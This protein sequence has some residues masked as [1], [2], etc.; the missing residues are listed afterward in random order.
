MVL[1]KMTDPPGVW[2]VRRGRLAAGTGR[3]LL[4]GLLFAFP[5]AAFAQDGGGS[6]RL[7]L[8]E[9]NQPLSNADLFPEITSLDTGT[10][11]AD[12]QPVDL[13]ARFVTDGQGHGRIDITAELAPKW[14]IYS[15]TQP[16]GGPTRTRITITGPAAVKLLSSFSPNNEPARSVSA[17]YNGLT[18]EEHAARVV[19]S[20]P[21][22]LP[23]GFDQGIELKVRGL[24]CRSDDQAGRCLPVSEKLTAKH[25][26]SI[27]DHPIDNVNGGAVALTQADGEAETAK[28]ESDPFRDGKY[29]VQW[30]AAV[31]PPH[32]QP[33]SSGVIEFTAEPKQEYHVYEAATDDRDWATN[34][35]VTEKSGLQVGK[36]TANRKLVSAEILPGSEPQSFYEGEVT[37]QLPFTVPP[38]LEPG[39]KKIQGMIAY[40]A[41]TL[42]SCYR[43]MALKFAIELPVG[44]DA[45][46]PVRFVLNKEKRAVAMDAAAETKWVDP[47]GG[48]N[49]ATEQED[50]EELV[51]TTPVTPIGELPFP[52][53]LGMAFLGGLILNV[54]PCVL[55]VVG[56]KIMG[57][58]SQAGEDRGRVLLLNLVYSLGILSLFAVLAVLAAVFKFGWGE[59]FTFFEVK[60]ALTVLMFAL[61]LSYLGVWEIPIPGMAGGAA[62]MELQNREGLLGAFSKGVFATILSTPCS[63]PLLGYILGAT[64]GFTPA[65][66]ILIIMTVGLGMAS[67]YL[68][69]GAQPKLVAWLPKPGP[70]METLK[71]LMAFLF[72]GTVAYFFAQFSD[73]Q[74]VPV[75]VSLIAVWFGCWIIGQVPNWADIRKRLV[76]WAGGIAA[77]VVISIGA[78][79]Y[80]QPA[81]EL[82]WVDYNERRLTQ[83]QNEGRTVLLDFSAKWCATCQVNYNFA[84][85]TSETREVLDEL[86][87]VAMYADWTDYNEE[88]KQKLE[89]LGS[90]SIPLLAIY[91]GNRPG[92]PIVLRDVVTQQQVI[93][94]LRA[95]GASVSDSAVS[96]TPVSMAASQ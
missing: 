93:D 26:G 53:L 49:A 1:K 52:W 20:A 33:G 28:A 43:P 57:F 31:S 36:P 59:Q 60:F 84:I 23:T 70:W 42:K 76:A 18:V 73:Y 22:S 15:V 79:Q 41:C 65:R 87:G 3:V 39:A 32:P 21:V 82:A 30:S 16:K 8:R 14:H 5:A 61:A 54:M 17:V 50:D 24:V 77:A 90:I 7:K 67:P 75:F 83:L 56:L 37:F 46:A 66:T 89:E 86:D 27:A 25:A 71:Q 72:L 19:W 85:N 48:D 78:F 47:I 44:G 12:Q 45:D 2:M 64:L 9:N 38:N 4:I 69:I 35:V 81:D 74:K 6:S 80:L 29:V 63:G 88:I 34:F 58:V 55:P 10:A 62:S 95:A 92:E 94:A 13:S 96:G 51:A 91:P 40:Q 11:S 68:L